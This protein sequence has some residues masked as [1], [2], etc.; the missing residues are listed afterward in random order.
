MLRASPYRAPSAA[1]VRSSFSP[2]MP[3][4]WRRSFAGEN[5]ATARDG[6]LVGE[7]RLGNVPRVDFYRII[8]WGPRSL[9]VA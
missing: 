9:I 7:G 5:L 8:E 2:S 6:A 3:G 1:Q 4:E